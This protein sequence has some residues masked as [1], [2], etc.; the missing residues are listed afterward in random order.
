MFLFFPCVL[1]TFVPKNIF[2]KKKKKK[3]KKS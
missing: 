2:K 1:G 3:K